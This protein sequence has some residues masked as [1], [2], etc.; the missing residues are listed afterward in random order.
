MS[1]SSEFYLT[2][3]A[4]SLR[5]ADASTLNNVRERCLRSAASWQ[6]MAERAAEMEGNRRAR[7]KRAADSAADKV[8]VCEPSAVIA[9]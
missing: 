7:E 8:L 6:A 5:D 3:A 1:G 9:A 2:C 4:Q